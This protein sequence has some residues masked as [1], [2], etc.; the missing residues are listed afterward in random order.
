M[1]CVFKYRWGKEFDALIIGTA[2]PH[3]D[4][5]FHIYDTDT[6]EVCPN[7]IMIILSKKYCCNLCMT[8]V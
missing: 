2:A 5:V 7:V 6:I 3:G 4:P 8:L 1:I